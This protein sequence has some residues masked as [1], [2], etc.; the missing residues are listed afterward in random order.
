MLN[1]YLKFRGPDEIKQFLQV[2]AGFLFVF[3]DGQD[4]VDVNNSKQIFNQ[5]IDSYTPASVLAFG[6]WGQAK[7]FMDLVYD[8]LSINTTVTDELNSLETAIEP[9]VRSEQNIFC[10]RLRLGE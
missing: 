3:K 5:T 10:V 6:K 9:P 2:C 1:I 8:S 7:D 4:K